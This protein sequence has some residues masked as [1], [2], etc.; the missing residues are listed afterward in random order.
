VIAAQLNVSDGGVMNTERPLNNSGEKLVGSYKIA[1][2]HD[3]KLKY[4]D[5]THYNY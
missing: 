4:F 1:I 3:K 5:I 2:T